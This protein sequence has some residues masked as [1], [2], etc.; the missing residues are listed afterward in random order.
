VYCEQCGAAVTPGARF[1]E[2]CGASL[3][4]GAVKPARRP[5]RGIKPR[6]WLGVV[7]VGGVVLLAV[8]TVVVV[9]RG[10][11]DP[12][13][14]ADSLFAEANRLF[15]L[16]QKAE[17]ESYV[18]ALKF[19]KGVLSRIEKITTFYP[20]TKVAGELVRGEARVGSYTIE[21]FN[22]EFKE[23]VIPQMT[24]KAEA[25]ESPLA[26]ALLVA[27]TIEDANNKAW[28][29]AEIAGAYA[30][31]GQYDQAL[32][33]AATI[34][35]AVSQARALAETASQYAQAGQREKAAELFS[36]ALQATQAV[37]NT[38]EKATVLAEIAGKYA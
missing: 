1:C 6:E 37:T 5:A 23:K 4:D 14:R 8:A 36:Q 34:A 2:E 20:S 26:C 7:V 15:E 28:S 33:V 22:T 3:G 25:E 30:K 38:F 9:F 24:V 32:Q 29:L 17:G 21:E 18:E 35:T 31:A 13:A 12:E 11:F 10:L 27:R 19:Y 16:A